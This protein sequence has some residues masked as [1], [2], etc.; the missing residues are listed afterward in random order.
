MA[1]SI[2]KGRFEFK[3]NPDGTATVQYM[4]PN[5]EFAENTTSFSAT[6]L[7]RIVS[8]LLTREELLEIAAL[9]AVAAAST[10]QNRISNQ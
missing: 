2:S 7:K 4:A 3:R 5:L 6:D 1:V 8:T 9:K 10:I